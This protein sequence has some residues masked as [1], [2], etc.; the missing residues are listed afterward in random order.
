MMTDNDGVWWTMVDDDGRL[1]H[2]KHEWLQQTWVAPKSPSTV[3]LAKAVVDLPRLTL[4]QG[5]R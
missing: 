2:D 1:Q 3:P 5:S 4:G